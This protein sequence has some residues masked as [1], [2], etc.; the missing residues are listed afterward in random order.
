MVRRHAITLSAAAAVGVVVLVL[1]RMAMLPGVGFWD[2]AELQTVGPVLGVAH[3]TGFPAWVVLGWLASVV[4]QPFGD[5]AFRMNLLSGLLVAGSAAAT[6]ILVGLL[7]RSTVLGV[8]AGLGLGTTTLVWR[9]GTIADAHALHLLLVALLFLALVLWQREH[10]RGGG[11]RWLVAASAIFGVSV[12]NHSLTLLLAPPVALYV[13][14][15]DP[16]LWRRPRVVA[17]CAAVLAAVVVVLYLE[18]P[19]RAGP[20]RAPLVYGTPETWDGFRYIVLAE[21]F[22]GSIVDPFGELPRK[23]GDVVAL[24]VREL[25]P[26]AALLPAALLVTAVRQPRYALLS[27]LAL[28]ITVFFAAS[29]QNADIER[30]YLAPILIVWTWLAILA[31][32]VA[33]AVEILGADA[34]RGGGRRTASAPGAHRALVAT[35]LGLGLM[36]P[37]S[38]ELDA[39]AAAVDRSKDVGAQRWLDDTIGRL[40]P[41]AVVISWWSYSTPL[42]YAQHVEG[43]LP[44]V[45]IADDRTRLDRQLGEVTDVIERFVGRRPVYLIRQSADE[46]LEIANTYRLEPGPQP[47]AL[48]RVVGP[49]TADE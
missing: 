38:L 18:L 26:L 48:V 7:T 13:L 45:L 36:L 6:V 46:L 14:S 33:E 28:G 25:G 29:Y 20:F 8:A 40:E 39:R 3:P 31:A 9:I 23:A 2:T 43:R 49:L 19:L 24:V 11:H 32:A 30:Y 37:A 42:W 5:P 1:C 27:A 12:A 41:E 4:L 16:R 15:V 21:Q 34:A 47:N 10:A 44:G 22:R 17:W 35:V